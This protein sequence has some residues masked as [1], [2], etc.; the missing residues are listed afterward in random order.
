MEKIHILDK[1]KIGLV[2]EG[3]GLR[4]IF[5]AGVLDYFLKEELI[6]PYAIGTSAGACNLLGYAA[7]QPGHTKNSMIQKDAT[8]H[9][10][11]FNQLIE[12]GKLIDLDKIFYEYSYNQNPFDFDTYFA[13]E[14]KCEYV[15]T[16]CEDGKAEYL[17]ETKDKH[18]LA[19]IG[20]A[21]SSMP[22]FTSMVDLDGKKYLDGSL[23]DSVALKR[24][25][26]MGCEKNVVI[27]TRRQ[28][29]YPKLT[30]YQ[31]IIYEGFYRKYPELLNTILK[32]EKMYQEEMEYLEQKEK[33]GSVFV[34]RPTIPEINRM[35]TNYQVLENYYKHGYEA[36]SVKWTELK[37]FLECN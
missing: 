37:R 1:T 11:G 30:T 4:G 35:E 2:T 12:N 29:I 3:G 21:S 36:A 20:K 23:S 6:F 34:I 25:E 19:T 10:Y 5:T 16:N 26:D 31:K 15:V 14:T 22:L 17:S 27:L 18:R 7:K 24:A 13:S 9:Y 32:R 28:G 33:E 8:N